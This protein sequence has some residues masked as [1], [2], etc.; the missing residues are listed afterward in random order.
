VFIILLRCKS[1]LWSADHIKT[2]TSEG[3]PKGMPI[4]KKKEEEEEEG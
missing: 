4:F 2:K 3:T 1:H